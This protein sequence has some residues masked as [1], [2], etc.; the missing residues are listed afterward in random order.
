[1][2]LGGSDGISFARRAG[3]KDIDIVA[4]NDIT[5]PKTLA[6]LLKYDSVLGNLKSDV[7][8]R[9][10][11]HQGRR[12]DASRSSRKRIRQRSI[13]RRWVSDRCRRIDR[14]VHQCRR[15][16]QTP[17]RLGEEGHHLRTCQRAKTSRSASASMTR[18]TIPPKHHVIS[19]ASCTTNCLA[20]IAKVVHESFG[21]ESGSDDDHSLL[22]ERPEASRSAALRIC[23][24]RELLR[25]R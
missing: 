10:R 23:D 19:N 16:A 11:R 21:I 1:M 15:C 2:V 24:V 5:D 6:H 20:P 7:T 25:C 13:G 8:S 12:P 9:R 3:D 14:T 17:A 4:V 18:A 22:H